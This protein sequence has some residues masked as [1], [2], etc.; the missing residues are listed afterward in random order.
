M[1]HRRI[2]AVGRAHTATADT[3]LAGVPIRAGDTLLL[4]YPSANRDDL[5]FAG[6]DAFDIHRQPNDHLAF[7]FG[8]HFCLDNSLGRLEITTKLDRLLTRLPDLRP[9]TGKPAHRPANF[10]SGYETMPVAFTPTARLAAS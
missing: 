7:G 1:G 2:A 8:P 4:L 3:T 6:P 5:H 9:T 10:V